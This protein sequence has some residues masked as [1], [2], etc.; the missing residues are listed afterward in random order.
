MFSFK[1]GTFKKST[2]KRDNIDIIETVEVN[3]NYRGKETEVLLHVVAFELPY[4]ILGRA[5]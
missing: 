4:V 2:F 3:L 5:G 1:P